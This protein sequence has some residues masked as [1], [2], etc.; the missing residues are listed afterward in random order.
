MY[1]NKGSFPLFI[2]EGEST[3][4]RIYSVREFFGLVLSACTILKKRN[5]SRGS[6]VLIYMSTSIE[7]AAWIS[8]YRRNLGVV[9]SCSSVDTSSSSIKE[10]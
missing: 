9:Y 3:T 10:Y 8:A 4:T 5:I 1:Q 2:F 7:S 6:R